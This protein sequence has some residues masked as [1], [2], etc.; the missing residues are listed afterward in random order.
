MQD[1]DT[2]AAI[3]SR[4]YNALTERIVVLK[5]RSSLTP[6]PSQ[7]TGGPAPPQDGLP[8]SAAEASSESVAEESSSAKVD[9]GARENVPGQLIASAATPL[10]KETHPDEG[11]A[12]TDGAEET[13]NPASTAQQGLGSAPGPDGDHA[14]VEEGG[15]GSKTSST[16]HSA[17]EVAATSEGGKSGKGIPSEGLSEADELDFA[18]KLSLDNPGKDTAASFQR[19]VSSPGGGMGEGLQALVDPQQPPPTKKPP[20]GSA[21]TGADLISFSETSEPASEAGGAGMPAKQPFKGSGAEGLTSVTAVHIDQAKP[22]SS[23]QPTKPHEPKETVDQ[24]FVVIEPEEAPG[25]GF[26]QV[27]MPTLPS[28]SPDDFQELK[29]RPAHSADT[30]QQ[31]DIHSKTDTRSAAETLPEEELPRTAMPPGSQKDSGMPET[32]RADGITAQGLRSETGTTVADSPEQKYSVLD[33]AALA[34]LAALPEPAS[35]EGL[36]GG[37]SQP[38]MPENAVR[39]QE[40]AGLQEQPALACA[41]SPAAAGPGSASPGKEADAPPD[42]PVD[43]EEGITEADSLEKPGMP[44]KG[45]SGQQQACSMGSNKEAYLIQSFLDNASSQLT[46][47]GLISL[48]QVRGLKTGNCESVVSKRGCL[49]SPPALMHFRSTRCLV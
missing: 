49:D 11:K 9:A 10:G 23:L 39:S 48:H 33:G 44:D 46:E 38:S 1:R 42:I 4:S 14:V 5:G 21:S 31:P 37:G 3:G 17:H 20:A 8:L 2:A 40:K 19:P 18:L 29:Q 28:S 45:V 35:A 26:E 36:N 34:L 30:L 22:S 32:G 25:A 16:P 47:H 15:A 12:H 7:E 27:S 41:S 43:N 13:A 6:A 24:G